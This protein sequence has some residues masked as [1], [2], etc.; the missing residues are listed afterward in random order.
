MATGNGSTT[1]R[2]YRLKNESGRWLA[3]VVISDDGYFSTVSDYGNYAYWWSHAGDCFRSFL[4]HLNPDYLCSKLGGAP[5]FY[6]ADATEKNIRRAICRARRDGAIGRDEAREEWDLLRDHPVDSREG[7]AMWF[8]ETSLE[9]AA[10]FSR[11]THK[12]DLLGFA[13][14][15]WPVLARRLREELAG[16]KNAA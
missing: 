5:D 13:E 6:D 3:D 11:W 14:R 4:A 15:V 1:L 8:Q 16:E 2:R 7:F 12:P 9:D 10:D